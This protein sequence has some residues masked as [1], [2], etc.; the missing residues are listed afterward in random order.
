MNPDDCDFSKICG[1]YIITD[2]GGEV[3]QTPEC[4][5]EYDPKGTYL[6]IPVEVV[7]FGDFWPP[8][9]LLE[10]GQLVAEPNGH[11]GT[12]P[13]EN[14]DRFWMVPE[15]VKSAD[16]TNEDSAGGRCL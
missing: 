10:Y 3:E 7:P 16:L 15:K 13:F 2:T 5:C 11:G 4:N 12:L 8:N 1:V 14:W 9:E 6:L